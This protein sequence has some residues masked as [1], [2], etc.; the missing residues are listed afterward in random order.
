M[1]RDVIAWNARIVFVNHL[2]NT[3]QQKTRLQWYHHET[4]RLHN[5]R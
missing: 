5:I 1:S 3:V 4:V 2:M